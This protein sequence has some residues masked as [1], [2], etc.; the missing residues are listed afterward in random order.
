MSVNFPVAEIFGPVLQGE[1]PLAGRPT[2]FVRT[3]GCDFRCAWC[4]TMWAVLPEKVQHMPRMMPEDVA[5]E[6]RRLARGCRTPP[7]VTLTGGNPAMWHLGPLVDRLHMH[8]HAVAI[9][10][11]GSL[12]P[13]WAARLDYITVSPKPPSSGQHPLKDTWVLDKWL[14]L[15]HAVLKVVVADDADLDWVMDFAAHRSAPTYLQPC[16]AHT[17]PTG[18]SNEPLND[19]Q[20]LDVLA[21]FA[22]LADKVMARGWSNVTVLPQLHVIANGGGPGR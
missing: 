1:G 6:V 12:W 18:E 4:D 9:E 5:V 20:R 19:A 2:I 10:T 8:G 3:G 15:P 11:Q 13:D 16:N 14:A 21:A 7:V 17:D 22:A